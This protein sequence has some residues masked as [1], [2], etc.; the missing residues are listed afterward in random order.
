VDTD[1]HI[2]LRYS[3]DRTALL[4]SSLLL[5]LN[6]EGIVYGNKGFVKVGV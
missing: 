1:C 5:D 6:K 4:S 2:F 3:N